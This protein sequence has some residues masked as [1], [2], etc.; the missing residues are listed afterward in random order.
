MNDYIK[1][2]DKNHLLRDTSSNGIVNND[3][4][5]Y[6]AYVQNYSRS[7]AQNKNIQN[8]E[9]QVNELKNDLSE[10]KILLRSL[11]NGPE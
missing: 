5:S 10:I 8:L 1:V 4:E 11:V 2:K 6:R 9:C 3:I 7:Q